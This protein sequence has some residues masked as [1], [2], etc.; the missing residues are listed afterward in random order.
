MARTTNEKN[1]IQEILQ[2]W[3]ELNF[4]TASEGK[5]RQ[6]QKNLKFT[7]DQKMAYPLRVVNKL[8]GSTGLQMKI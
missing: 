6:K 5:K 4:S 2:R 1:T 7:G 8:E 3:I